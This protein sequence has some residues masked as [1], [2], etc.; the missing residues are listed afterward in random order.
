MRLSNWDNDTLKNLLVGQNKIAQKL[1]TNCDFF[2]EVAE[3]GII[4]EDTN[5]KLLDGDIVIELNEDYMMFYNN[6]KEE[7]KQAIRAALNTDEH[8][9]AKLDLATNAMPDA[10]IKEAIL[11]ALDNDDN[12][13]LAKLKVDLAARHIAAMLAA[14]NRDQC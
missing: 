3:V 5:F 12:Y 4:G 9:E 10:K 8:H 2:N 14:K 13:K 11:S 1:Y 7:I 6:H